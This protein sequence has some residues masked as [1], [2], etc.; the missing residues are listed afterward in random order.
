MYQVTVNN[1]L[2]TQVLNYMKANRMTIRGERIAVG[3]SGGPDSVCLLS[4]LNELSGGLGI[5]LTAVHVNHGIRGAEADADALFVQ[6][7]CRKM[8]IPFRLFSFDVPSLAKEQ[9]LSVEEA[10]RRARQEAFETCMQ[11]DGC[12][13][14]ALAHQMDDVAETMLFNLARGTGLAGLASMR[15]VR[16]RIIRPL[17]QTPRAEI[18]SYLRENHISYRT[19]ATNA[20]DEYARNRIRSRIL[21]ALEKDVNT[22]AARH[23]AETSARIR[24]VLSFLE[25]E[26]ERYAEAC[27]VL[28]NGTVVLLAEPF[29]LVPE[30]LRPEL[31]RLAFVKCG[32]GLRDISKE[33]IEA[34]L[35][36]T[37]KQV[38]KWI[39]LPEGLR[40]ERTYEGVRF[41]KKSAS[42]P[43]SDPALSASSPP[44]LPLSPAPSVPLPVPLPVPGTVTAFGYEI[45]SRL[46]TAVPFPIPEKEC[47][48]WFDYG[49]ITNILTIRTRLAGDILTTTKEGG[50]KSLS[51]WFIGEKIP[52]ER[53]DAMPLLADGHRVL[54]IFGERIGEDFKVTP[55][56]KKVLKITIREV[57]E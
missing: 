27:L 11:E 3:V 38:G 1:M 52:R 17:L 23:L 5:R 37:D 7:L 34:V 43:A 12:S 48:K 36:L 49:K 55:E 41:R 10:G 39:S 16:G 21:P 45:T 9:K 29:R 40:A 15:P 46:L 13:R 32:A 8:E 19:D 6:E 26:T 53:R 28:E 56:T 22:G 54:W 47:T 33:H 44:S 2:K 35:A 18:L 57:S 51:H 24:E 30:A 42:V 25:D 20:T 31:V 14:I 4:V 50:R